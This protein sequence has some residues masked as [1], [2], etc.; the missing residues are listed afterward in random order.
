MISLGFQRHADWE[1]VY[2]YA[3]GNALY[4]IHTDIME[5]DVSDKADYKG[6]FS[7]M[8][9]HA[10]PDRPHSFRFT[11]EFHFL[12]M[13][14]HIAKHVHGSGAGVRMYLDVAA[15]VLHYGTSKMPGD[16]FVDAAEEKAEEAAELL[17]ANGFTPYL[18]TPTQGE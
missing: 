6:Y 9:D 11:P 2:S 8:W 4:E 10:R 5:I 3:G 16:H 7:G 14:T 1:P 13:L 17:R 12:Y 15:F 18:C